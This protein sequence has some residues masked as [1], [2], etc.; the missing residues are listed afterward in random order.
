[1]KIK[2]FTCDE[3]LSKYIDSMLFNS[4]EC[5]AKNEM[6]EICEWIEREG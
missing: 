6:L 2:N 3:N 4:G 1:M 5:I